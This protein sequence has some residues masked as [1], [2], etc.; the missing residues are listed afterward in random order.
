MQQLKNCA[1]D[2]L[3]NPDFDRFGISV[4][5][6]TDPDN[7]GPDLFIDPADIKGI[8]IFKSFCAQM[9]EHYES[10]KNKI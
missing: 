7:C 5:V 9:Q 2:C 4:Y 8:E 3:S 1:Y 10:L 6:G